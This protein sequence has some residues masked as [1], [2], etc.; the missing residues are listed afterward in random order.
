MVRQSNI[1]LLRLVA[2][3]LVVLVHANY[4]SLGSVGLEDIA[5][6]P[7]NSFCKALA[8]QL[9]II[10]VNVF[11][12][13]S[14]WFGIKPSIKGALSLLFQIFFFHILIV[15]CVYL[16]GEPIPLK[17]IAEVFY[18]GY[19]YWFIVSYLILYSLAPIL[20][21]FIEF[22]S[23]KVFISVLIAFFFGEFAYGWA[24]GSPDFQDGYSTLSFVGLYLLAQFI[25]RHS[26]QLQSI[27]VCQNFLLYLFFTIVPVSIY[28]TTG[29]A[30]NTI[31]YCSPFVIA[32]SVFFF[33]AFNKIKITNTVINWMACSA[34]SIYLVHLHPLITEY[35]KNLMNYAYLS[36]GGYWYII[37]AILF[38][39]CMGITCIILDKVRIALWKLSCKLVIDKLILKFNQIIEKTYTILDLNEIDNK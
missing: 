37:F 30:F 26:P 15:G 21:I 10:C 22:A 29:H 24:A 11:I 14:G 32:A 12:L 36:L 38:A 35:F 1:E 33:M 5:S 34:L 27:G 20:N 7:F 4:Y 28:F 2:M 31:A 16:A 18:F 25:K 13:I 9:C 6:S 3:L 23:R 17:Q 39:I 8:E 19:S